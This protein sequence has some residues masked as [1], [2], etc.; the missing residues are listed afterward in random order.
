MKSGLTVVAVFALAASA[1]A[2]QEGYRQRMG[3]TSPRLDERRRA[4]QGFAD[5][6][7]VALACVDLAATE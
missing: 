4:W 1:C 7:G 5:E 2:T 3:A 6:A